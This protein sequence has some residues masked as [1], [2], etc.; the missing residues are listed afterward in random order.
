MLTLDCRDLNAVV[1]RTCCGSC[2]S[3]WE[4]GYDDPFD[5]YPPEGRPGRR[6]RDYPFFKDSRR[7][8]RIVLYRC[9]GLPD[10]LTRDQWATMARRR[11]AL[12]RA[13]QAGG[14]VR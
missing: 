11:R 2:H 7:P 13:R 6:R 5:Y 12:D 10:E 3:E 4:D 14:P 1:A 9:C 8:H